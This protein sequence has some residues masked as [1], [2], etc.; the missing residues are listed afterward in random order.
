MHEQMHDGREGFVGWIGHGGSVMQ[1]HPETKVSVGYV[2]FDF[3]DTDYS[4]K[5]GK[6]LQ[7]IVMAIV[8]KKAD[9]IADAKDKAI[10]DAKA[11]ADNAIS[12]D[13]DAIDKAIAEDPA[14]KG[15]TM[16]TEEWEKDEEG[17]N[18]TKCCCC[19]KIS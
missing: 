11:I 8:N 1:W 18:V 2:P 16:Y 4:N 19:I 3:L 12:I 13:D 9:T 6:E 10:A 14:L 15:Y 5:R 17:I 7:E